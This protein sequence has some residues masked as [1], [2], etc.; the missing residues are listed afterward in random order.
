MLAG[1]LRAILTC[2]DPRQ[3]DGRFIG[4]EFDARCWRNCPRR[5]IPAA[6]AASFIPSATR[7]RCLQSQFRSASRL[8]AARRVSL[9][10]LARLRRLV[11]GPDGLTLVMRRLGWLDSL[12]LPEEASRTSLIS[13][14]DMPRWSMAC[15]RA[16]SNSFLRYGT[17]VPADRHSDRQE[18][19]APDKN[20]RAVEQL[21]HSWTSPCVL[22]LRDRGVTPPK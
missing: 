9:P 6:A 18:E 20:K 2:V 11:L 19:N 7:G 5:S 8:R 14:A 1:G 15:L 3:L 17:V 10:R 12:D 22:A 21:R 13:S 16:A 4:R